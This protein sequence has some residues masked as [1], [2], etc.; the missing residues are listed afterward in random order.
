MLSSSTVVAVTC[1]ADSL[2]VCARTH[3]PLAGGTSVS[4]LYLMELRTFIDGTGPSIMALVIGAL[5]GKTADFDRELLEALVAFTKSPFSRI[6]TR[7]CVCGSKRSISCA[8][9]R[10]A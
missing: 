8:R 10:K 6:A 3:M 9:P 4:A 7:R 5:N 2:S 1:T